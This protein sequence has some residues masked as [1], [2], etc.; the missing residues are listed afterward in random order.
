MER[1]FLLKIEYD[2]SEFSGWQRQ[3]NVRT[4]QGELENAL[5]R[6]CG[7]PITIHGT[8]RTDAGVHAFGQQASF[9]GE[10]GIPTERIQLAVNNI[11]TGGKNMASVVGD[12]RVVELC[13]KDL[14]FHARFN[15][16]GKK[17]RYIINNSPDVDIFRRKYCYQIVRPLD[18]EGMKKAAKYIVGTHDFACF[19]SAGGQVCETTVRT[20]FSLDIYNSGQDIIIEIAGDGFLYNMVRNITGTLVEVGLGKKEP[21]DL[22]FIIQSKNRE[23]AGHKAPAGGLY[24][25]EVYYE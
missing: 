17:Y 25:V 24:L 9:K 15:A 3:P 13:Q 4:V 22:E 10:F 2:G 12:V 11:L 19:Q 6:V 1:N 8:S 23:N 20:V 14:D 16:C 18:I 5:S 7:V 21:E